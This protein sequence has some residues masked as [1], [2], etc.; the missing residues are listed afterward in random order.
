MRGD[1][2]GIALSLSLILRL[3]MP[4]RDGNLFGPSDT[5]PIDPVALPR[6]DLMVYTYILR[7]HERTPKSQDEDIP[8]W[9]RVLVDLFSCLCNTLEE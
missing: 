1:T 2:K 8:L 9:V 3:N 7:H 6:D 5:S 4:K